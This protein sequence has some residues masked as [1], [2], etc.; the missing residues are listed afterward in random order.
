MA[1]TCAYFNGIGAS[2]QS[3]PG[4]PEQIVQSDKTRVQEKQ[5]GAG[6]SETK[7]DHRERPP[8]GND[9]NERP[10]PQKAP[11][12][13]PKGEEGLPT[14]K[15]GRQKRGEAKPGPNASPEPS[16]LWRHECAVMTV[17]F[18]RDGKP[19]S[20]STDGTMERGDTRPVKTPIPRENS[21]SIT[22]MAFSPDGKRLASGSS[23]GTV[24]LWDVPREKKPRTLL[25][26]TREV[27][28][29][30]FSSDGKQLASGS[31]DKTVKLWNTETGKEIPTSMRQDGTVFSVAFSPDGK[32]LASGS[33]DGTVKLWNTETG[34]KICTLPG[35]SES[36][37]SVAFSPDGKQLAS[38][39]SDGNVRIWEVH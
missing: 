39:S 19:T 27:D 18:S 15:D 1:V 26:H 16:P 38:G 3:K 36:V 22:S 2:P 9:R 34:E 6:I 30:A 37:N 8:M 23:D 25:G 17:A 24:T 31:M 29:V 35:H 21:T 11:D 33:K 10:Q 32:R 20:G 13:L 12:S 28:S 5:P 14:N 7:E 4:T